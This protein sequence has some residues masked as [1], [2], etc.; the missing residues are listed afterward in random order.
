[1]YTHHGHKIRFSW[2]RNTQFAAAG[3]IKQNRGGWEPGLASPEVFQAAGRSLARW[4]VL[5]FF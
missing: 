4:I 3:I 5:E 2:S 1:L